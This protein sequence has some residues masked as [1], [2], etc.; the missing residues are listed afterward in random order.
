MAN[1]EFPIRV[2][3]QEYGGN[4]E[5]LSEIIFSSFPKLLECL[6]HYLIELKTRNNFEII[7]DFFKIDPDGAGK[8][9]VNYWLSWTSMQRE[10]FN[11]FGY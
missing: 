11:E 1:I 6:T 5:G 8:T 3:D 4:L 10:N 9:G 2:Y 7:P